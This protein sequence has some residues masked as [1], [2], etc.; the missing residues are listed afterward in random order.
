ML[1]KSNT[2]LGTTGYCTTFGLEARSKPVSKQ[3][4]KAPKEGA[5]T[6]GRVCYLQD[7]Y[8]LEQER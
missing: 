1:R 2:A 4:P 8:A 7:P 5:R 6:W 3:R